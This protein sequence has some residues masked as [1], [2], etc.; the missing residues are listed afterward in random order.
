MLAG[1][2]RVGEALGQTPPQEG[3]QGA[4]M[5]GGLAALSW[6]SLLGRAGAPCSAGRGRHPHFMP[7]PFQGAMRGPQSPR[8]AAAFP[9]PRALGE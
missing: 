3:G 2:S 4:S 6:Q 7:E 9:E 8:C 1:N 5:G